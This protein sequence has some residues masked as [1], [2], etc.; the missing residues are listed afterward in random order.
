MNKETTAVFEYILFLIFCFLWN[1]RIEY[2][3]Y[4]ILLGIYAI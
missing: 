4:S 3:H 1:S 2:L